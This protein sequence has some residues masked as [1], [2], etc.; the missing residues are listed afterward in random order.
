M[1]GGSRTRRQNRK[2]RRSHVSSNRLPAQREN[3]S[4]AEQYVAD[5]D[6]WSPPP[7]QIDDEDE[8][9]TRIWST[10]GCRLSTVIRDKPTVLLDDDRKKDTGMPYIIS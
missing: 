10:T 9:N 2:A 1:G 4:W 8:T 6:D 5:S 3:A 7:D